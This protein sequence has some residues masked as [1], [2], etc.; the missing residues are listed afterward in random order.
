[1]YLEVRSKLAL[2]EVAPFNKL[3]FFD[4]IPLIATAH[5]LVA[6]TATAGELG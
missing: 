6:G 2:T 1:M 3:P 4:L 5:P